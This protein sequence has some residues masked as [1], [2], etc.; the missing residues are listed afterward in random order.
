VILAG[1]IRP[2]MNWFGEVSFIE[3]LVLQRRYA[4]NF[5]ILAVLSI[6]SRHCHIG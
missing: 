5:S 1:F 4:M 3:M 6:R 2:H